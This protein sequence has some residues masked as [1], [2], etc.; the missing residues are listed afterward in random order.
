MVVHHVVED[1]T[2]AERVRLIDEASEIVGRA[3]ETRRREKIHTVV[4]PPVAAGKIR[5][6]HDFDDRD[7]GPGEL[8][9]LARRGAPGPLRGEG[10]HV[11]LVQ[12]LA[13]ERNARPR[14]IRPLEPCGVDH[15]RGP[16]R[17]LRLKARSGVRIQGLI[18]IES[19]AVARAGIDLRH[20]R[21][22]IAVVFRLQRRARAAACARFGAFEV[23]RHAFS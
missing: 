22:E 3:V 13:A 23:E 12:H 5:H 2:E 18:L 4:A 9:E 11:Q 8:C 6:R 1:D 15:L 20:E 7:A 10:A 16:V 19:K 21:G 14:L 17:P